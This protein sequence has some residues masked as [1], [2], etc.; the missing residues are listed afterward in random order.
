MVNSNMALYKWRKILVH[1][2]SLWKDSI[3]RLGK[4]M[5]GIIEAVVHSLVHWM[6]CEI[7]KVSNT[8]WQVGHHE[9]HLAQCLIHI[10]FKL[11]AFAYLVVHWKYEDI[12]FCCHYFATAKSKR[13][14][15]QLCLKRRMDHCWPSLNFS[16]QFPMKYRDMNIS[17]YLHDK[18]PFNTAV[19]IVA[20]GLLYM[21]I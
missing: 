16:L 15:F 12:S 21:S 17:L 7:N 19:L 1:S 5:F 13:T 8:F 6:K 9:P 10:A 3:K 2:N 11:N 4:W 14:L 20:I 18:C